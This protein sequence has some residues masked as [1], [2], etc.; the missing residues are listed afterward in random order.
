[1]AAAGR[2]HFHEYFTQE[3]NPYSNLGDLQNLF[4]ADPTL[5]PASLLSEADATRG[6]PLSFLMASSLHVPEV[7][8]MPFSFGL[9]G[10][11]NNRYA[12]LN[13]MSAAGQTPDMVLVESTWFHLSGQ[14]PVPTNEEMGNQW[15]ANPAASLL[16]PPP[17][18]NGVIQTQVRKCVPLPHEYASMIILAKEEGT[19]TWHWLWDNVGET[20]RSDPTQLLAYAPFLDFLRVSST[21]R[22]PAVAGGPPLDPGT[23][24]VVNVARASARVKDRALLLATTYLPGLGG[25]GGLGMQMNQMQGQMNQQQQVLLT[26]QA[27]ANAPASIQR[28]NPQRYEQISRICEVQSEAD[29]AAFWTVYPAMRAGEWLGGL[30]S[31]CTTIAAELGVSPPILSPSLATD[32]GGGK[33]T[34]YTANHVTQGLSPFRIATYLNSA[35]TERMRRNMVYGFVGLGTGVAQA[36]ATTMVLANNEIEVPTNSSQFRA[37]LEGYYVLLLAVLGEHS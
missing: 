25:L 21:N 10:T 26:Q 12:F 31:T 37:L 6:Y 24:M 29:F 27:Q 33:F 22:T 32:I 17:A 19:L 11:P 14:V 18:G 34:A 28:K 20:M 4:R 9:P 35:S 15:A 23:E 30:E 7:A 3:T 36:D 8:I 13:D 5:T 16:P 2:I 1:M